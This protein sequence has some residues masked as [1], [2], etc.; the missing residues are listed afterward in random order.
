MVSRRTFL[1]APAS[2]LLAQNCRA[3][4]RYSPAHQLQRTQ[5]RRTDRA[6]AGDGDRE[7]GPAARRVEIRPGR[8]LRRQRHRGRDRAP[9][10]QGIYVLRE[11]TARY[12]GGAS[13]YR[14]VSEDGRHRHRRT[15]IP[16]AGRFAAHRPGRRHRR[17]S[18]SVPV[19]CTSSTSI[20][21][22]GSR[23]SPKSWRGTRRSIS[24]ATRRPGGATSTATTSSRTC[25]RKRR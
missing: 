5:R 21:T 11:R 23:T 22:W 15:E 10:S 8:R 13:G 19:C 9:V 25:T 20:T 4:D 3:G 16:G 2:P 18:T 6:P 7:D 12:P 17:A 1:A 14:E 24:S